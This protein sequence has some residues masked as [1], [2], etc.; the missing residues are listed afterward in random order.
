[1]KHTIRRPPEDAA[2]RVASGV[3]WLDRTIPDWR[4]R[5]SPLTFNITSGCN[6]V[7]GQLFGTYGGALND[8][9]VTSP[10]AGRLGFHAIGFDDQFGYELEISVANDN[11][12]LQAEWTRVLEVQHKETVDETLAKQLDKK[13]TGM[14]EMLAPGEPED[15][16]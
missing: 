6:C 16:T 15:A 3:L 4:T 11:A 7:L 5:V 14:A 13:K 12:A 1:M 9:I 2:V 8:R 10:Q